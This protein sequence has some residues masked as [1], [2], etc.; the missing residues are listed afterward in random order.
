MKDWRRE[1]DIEA[2]TLLERS[3]GLKRDG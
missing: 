2:V 3:D 1:F